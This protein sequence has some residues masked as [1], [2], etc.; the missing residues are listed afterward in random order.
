MEDGYPRERQRRDERRQIEQDTPGSARI[1]SDQTVQ[2]H[3]RF[4]RPLRGT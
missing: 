4:I 1:E 3:I 2:K